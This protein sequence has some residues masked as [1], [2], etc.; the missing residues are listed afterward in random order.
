MIILRKIKDSMGWWGGGEK[1]TPVPCWWECQLDAATVE[2]S[3]EAPQKIKNR[4][5][6][7]SSNPTCGYTSKENEISISKTYLH[8]HVRYCQDTEKIQV[9]MDGQMDEE[10][11][12]N[13]QWISIQPLKRRKSCHLQFATIWMNPE[14]ILLSKINQKQK[15]K[16]YDLTYLWNLEC[17]TH[18]TREYR[19]GG[20][21]PGFGLREN[22]ETLVK[23]NELSVTRWIRSGESNA[24][25]GDHSLSHTS[26]LLHFTKE[27]KEIYVG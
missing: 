27:K 24:Q 21:L 1:G 19:M 8:P 10:N 4:T 5:T 23:G 11:V 18:K 12:V 15:G 7:W 17:W 16:D 22:G 9:P 25:H 20:G 3:M 13:A 6:L 14:D 2:N 26:C